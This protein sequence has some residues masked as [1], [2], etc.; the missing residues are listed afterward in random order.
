MEY[1]HKSLMSGRVCKLT[2]TDEDLATLV[3]DAGVEHKV[4]KHLIHLSFAPMCIY[5]KDID[6][7]GYNANSV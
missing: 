3:D 4:N 1:T 6:N 7:G 5:E 2:G